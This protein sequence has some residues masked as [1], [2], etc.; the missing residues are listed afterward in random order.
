MKTQQIL[1]L[2][3]MGV[4]IRLSQEMEQV[5]LVTNE[6]GKV[7]TKLAYLEFLKCINSTMP[8]AKINENLENRVRKLEEFNA[9]LQRSTQ[10]NKTLIGICLV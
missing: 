5:V 8:Q 7:S 10:E 1:L 3:I 2:F 4:K 9:N 6:N